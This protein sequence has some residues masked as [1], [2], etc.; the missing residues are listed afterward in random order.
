M[1][2]YVKWEDPFR[3]DVR[4][5]FYGD[6]RKRH[7]NSAIRL[8]QTLSLIKDRNNAINF[9]CRQ[10]PPLPADVNIVIDYYGHAETVQAVSEES[11]TLTLAYRNSHEFLRFASVK[12][13]PQ[14]VVK[15]KF[16]RG[17]ATRLRY[18]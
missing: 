13:D 4:A 5:L 8:T 9:V 15:R 16:A 10:L 1:S 7:E 17:S 6:L 12:P 18:R 14:N 3:A 2:E 11:A